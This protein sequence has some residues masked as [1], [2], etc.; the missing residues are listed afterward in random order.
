MTRSTCAA[1]APE[2]IGL[3]PRTL[4]LQGVPTFHIGSEG[5]REVVEVLCRAGGVAAVHVPG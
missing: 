2:I 5:H 3:Q 4:G 1:R